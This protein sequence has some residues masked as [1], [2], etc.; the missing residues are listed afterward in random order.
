MTIYLAPV[1]NN[2][3][4]MP[5]SYMLEIFRICLSTE[6]KLLKKKKIKAAPSRQYAVS[7]IQIEVISKIRDLSNAIRG[8]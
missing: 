8:N 2:N 4:K 5:H 3:H 1:I 6:P 7:C